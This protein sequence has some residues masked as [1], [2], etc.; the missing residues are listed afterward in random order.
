M[1]L[2]EGPS[3]L[4]LLL[5]QAELKMVRLLLVDWEGYEAGLGDSESTQG[6][7]CS[8]QGW[9]FSEQG[10]LRCMPSARP[11]QHWQ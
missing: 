4:V 9:H 10:W 2:Q 5:L 1:E 3:L 11:R 6:R 8:E 7:H